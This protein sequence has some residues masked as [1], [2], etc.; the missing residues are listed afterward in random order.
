[1]AVEVLGA[2][3]EG[4][5]GNDE[6]N[7]T[8]AWTLY[9][10]GERALAQEIVNRLRHIR[11]E[12]SRRHSWGLSDVAY[13][14]RLRWLQAL[15]GIPEGEV[16][17]AKDAHE[18]AYV[19]VER[20][21]RRVGEWRARVARDEAPADR[22]SLFRSFLLFHNRSVHFAT[23]SPSH[24]FILQTSRKAIYEEVA[25]LA[26][27]MGMRGL[28]ALRDVVVELADGPAAVQF[29]PHHRRYFARLFWE[30]GAMAQDEAVA[31]G[32]SSTVD[33]DDEDPAE[34]ER[35]CLE[36]AA[37][38]RAVGEETGSAGWKGRASEVSAGAGSHKDYHMAHVS[39]WLTRSVAEGDRATL[40]ILEGFARAV[41]ISGGDGG[42][43]AAASTLRLSGWNRGVR[44]A[45]LW[46]R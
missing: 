18:E 2:A 32:L 16:P 35:A 12:A 37:F 7:L 20:T 13:T 23:V 44:G 39:E 4:A 42:T 17:K 26:K 5:G 6:L 34:R 45:W 9:R 41:E 30:E 14:A 15:L 11:F 24:N 29:A 38:L 27:A 22:R 25:G 40:E 28:G 19:R 1:M 3:H 8:Y 21:A 43:E 46:S 36:V 10:S 33:A 31:M